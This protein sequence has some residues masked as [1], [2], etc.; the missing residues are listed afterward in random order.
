MPYVSY[1]QHGEDVLLNQLFPDEPS[2]FYVDIGANDPVQFSVTKHFYDRGWSGINVEPV[3]HL[4]S[5]LR[6]ARP[7]DLNL[8]IGVSNREETLTFFESN[9]LAGWSTFSRPLAEAY[10]R[11]GLELVEWTIP[12]MT[13]A[14]LFTRH[15]DRP[16]DFLKINVE[17]HEREVVE[18][19]DWERCRPRV[20]LMENA[21]SHDWAH[22]IPESR[23]IEVHCD[24]Y[25]RYYIAREEADLLARHDAGVRAEFVRYNQTGRLESMLANL[26]TRDDLGPLARGVRRALSHSLRLV[27][28]RQRRSRRSA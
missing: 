11:R 15:V 6:E 8:N 24:P 2:G 23:Y 10:R 14:G 4:H 17:G 21:W 13:V 3:P 22:L 18:G 26:A 16:V 27:T 12:V 25:N 9:P 28:D 5:R 7:R 19:I 1:A 20:L